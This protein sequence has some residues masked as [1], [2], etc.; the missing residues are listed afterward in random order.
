[1]FD[2]DIK[3]KCPICKYDFLI[4]FNL[5]IKSRTRTSCMECQKTFMYHPKTG[6]TSLVNMMDKIKWWFEIRRRNRIVKRMKKQK[7]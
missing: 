7:D 3:I 6:K 4:S 5:N 1:M 2:D